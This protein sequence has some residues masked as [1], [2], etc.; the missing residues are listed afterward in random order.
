VRPH[1]AAVMGT[2][3][4]A[5]FLLGKNR[6]GLPGILSKVVGV[7]LLAAGCIYMALEAKSFVQM[8]SFSQTAQVLQRVSGGSLIGGSAFGAGQSLVMRVLN[9]PFLLFR[10]WPWEVHNL[11]SAIS[12]LE[13]LL[14]LWIFFKRRR[15]L[16]A[17]VRNWRSNAFVFFVLLVAL[18]L[19]I[20]LSAAVSNFGL[21]SRE[22]VMLLPFAMMLFCTRSAVPARMGAPTRAQWQS[23]PSG[24]AARA[25]AYRGGRLVPR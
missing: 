8:E 4:V 3:L 6:Q 19:S 14:L 18:Q 10:P 21:L 17:A 5:A 24:A 12:A 13:G 20:I 2:A 22:R 9:T 16:Y 23:Q 1:I 11:S 25:P 7:P 15:D